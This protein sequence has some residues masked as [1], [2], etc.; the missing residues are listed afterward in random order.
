MTAA[1]SKGEAEGPGPGTRLDEFTPVKIYPAH[2]TPG[3]ALLPSASGAA[4]AG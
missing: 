3:A 2:L 4:T 1:P